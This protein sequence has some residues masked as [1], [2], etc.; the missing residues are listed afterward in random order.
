MCPYALD[1]VYFPTRSTRTPVFYESQVV[2]SPHRNAVFQATTNHH[3]CA[4]SRLVGV[5]SV[6]FHFRRTHE[7]SAT[8]GE[9]HDTENNFHDVVRGPSLEGGVAPAILRRALDLCAPSNSTCPRITPRARYVPP[10]ESSFI[11]SVQRI[12]SPSGTQPLKQTAEQRGAL[13][14]RNQERE[15]GR[16]RERESNRETT[17]STESSDLIPT[18]SPMPPLPLPH[19]AAERCRPPQ[20]NSNDPVVLSPIVHHTRFAEKGYVMLH[21][22]LRTPRGLRTN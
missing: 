19:H 9:V 2:L 6:V 22:K 5:T 12:L 3:G 10:C 1:P 17:T 7:R 18:S 11:T 14:T 21:S 16:G 20:S 4:L 15:R 13:H 8:P